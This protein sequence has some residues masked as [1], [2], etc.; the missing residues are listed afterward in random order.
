MQGGAITETYDAGLGARLE[1][2]IKQ[3]IGVTATVEV[4]APYGLERSL[5]KAKRISD[6][7]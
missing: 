2:K 5:G 4:L 7:R 3:R 6:R 1:D